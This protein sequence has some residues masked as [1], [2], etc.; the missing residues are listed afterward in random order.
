[1]RE[2]ERERDEMDVPQ[3][4]AMLLFVR[5]DLKCRVS[6]LRA[7]SEER[8]EESQKE[9]RLP[10]D[11]FKW[12]TGVSVSARTAAALGLQVSILG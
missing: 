9:P 7:P 8:G 11:H 2:E 12:G 5:S 1:M 6:Q 3:P 10:D 4:L